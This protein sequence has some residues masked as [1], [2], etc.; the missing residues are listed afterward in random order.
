MVQRSVFF[1]IVASKD[2]SL[3]SEDV[4]LEHL[5]DGCHLVP[6]AEWNLFASVAGKR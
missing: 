1:F 2:T 5:V 3:D 4:F 6:M